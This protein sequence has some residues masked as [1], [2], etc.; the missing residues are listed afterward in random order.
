MVGLSARLHGKTTEQIFTKLKPKTDTVH[1]LVWIRTKEWVEKIMHEHR[2]PILDP[3]GKFYNR[4]GSGL[5]TTLS[6]KRFLFSPSVIQ[7]CP[8]IS[9]RFDPGNLLSHFAN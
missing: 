8:Y 9:S 5:G 3:S 6:E 2:I 1:F 7:L 4:S